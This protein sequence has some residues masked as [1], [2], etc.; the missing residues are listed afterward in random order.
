RNL[1][2]QQ[3]VDQAAINADQATVNFQQNVVNQDQSNPATDTA[4][5]NNEA[6][7]CAGMPPAPVT[8]AC[9][10]AQNAD[11]SADAS[12]IP[13]QQAQL[14]HDQAQLQIDQANLQ[15]AQAKARQNQIL[16]QGQVLTAQATLNAARNEGN[17]AIQQAQASLAQAQANAQHDVD[18]AQ[19]NLNNGLV[20]LQN[21]K[22]SFAS[23]QQTNANA[24]SQEQIRANQAVHQAQSQLDQAS[25]SLQ[26]LLAQLSA[27]ESGQ[28]PQQVVQD[29]AQVTADQQAVT[30]AENTVAGTSLVAPVAG[31]IEQVNIAQGQAI[32]GG[33][34]NANATG[35][36]TGAGALAA[37]AASGGPTAFNNAAQNVTHAIVLIT[38]TAFQVSGPVSDAQLPQVRP[39]DAVYVVPAGG[40]N[41][42]QGHVV[43]VA[44][45]AL[46]ASGVATFTVTAVVDSVSSSIHPGSTAQMS[47]VVQREVDV[48]TVP[49]SAVHTVGSSS[50]VLVP[51]N[52][53]SVTV[54]VT[55]GASDP[56][57]T[58]ITS[59]LHPGDVVVLAEIG[60]KPPS[61]AAPSG[62]AAPGGGGGGNRAGGGGARTG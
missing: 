4:A 40:G 5:D 44:P 1:S 46:T 62:G 55:I 21:A 2:A 24:I 32:G 23:A 59:G 10:N 43:G 34:G 15:G 22:T 11:E 29:A 50:Y 41:Q 37:S 42:L 47:I 49:S 38:P 45:A 26:G 6:T 30:A 39:A 25:S 19:G 9:T 13:N 58:Q 35:S 60:V 7:A 61:G 28:I 16:G 48:L 18:I 57:R 52:G 8:V 14:Q 27:L 17:A 53:Q 51:R 12:E 36:G 33:G 3:Q 56:Q 31:L 20:Q 54:P